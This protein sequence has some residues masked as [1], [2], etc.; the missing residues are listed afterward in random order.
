MKN[1]F[2]EYVAS[3]ETLH[4]KARLLTAPVGVSAS[5][6]ESY[7]NG[8]E[9]PL[10]MIF[11][12]HPDDESIVGLWPL[13]LAREAG[14][15]VMVCPVTLGSDPRRQSLRLEELRQAVG[16]LAWELMPEV[17]VRES[18]LTVAAV[19]ASLLKYRPAALFCPHPEDGHP[20]HREVRQT[21]SDSLAQM[22]GDF[23]TVV[24]E[25]EYWHT[26]KSP[27]ILVEGTATQVGDLVG[28]L[29]CHVG[30]VCRNPYHLSL[31]SWMVDSVRRGAE[32]LAGPG[33]Q[34]PDFC[35]GTLYRLSRWCQGSL[36]PMAPEAPLLSQKANPARDIRG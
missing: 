26:M 23:S 34:A 33:A 8:H 25:T 36:M 22:P 30:E 19:S 12:P 15:R 14:W 24:I 4:R 2:R 3:L 29:A 5:H 17:N 21:V 6:S 32:M 11:A 18:V 35:F 13:R 10:A 20:R 16:F 1:P 28:A 9:R 7:S 31:P 27:N